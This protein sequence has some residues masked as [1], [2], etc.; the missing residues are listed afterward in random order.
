VNRKKPGRKAEPE[1]KRRTIWPR[2]TGFRG[3]TAWDWMQLLIVP[4]VLTFLGLSF[5]AAQQVIANLQQDIRQQQIE[6]QRAEAEREL[7]E[8]RAQDE[9]LQAYLD[10]M[11]ELLLEHDLRDSGPDSSARAVANVQ[12]LLILERV[13]P[14]RKRS[15]LRLLTDSRL[16]DADAPV[17]DLDDASL[18]GADVSGMDLSG[19]DLS[20]ANLSDAYLSNADLSDANLSGAYLSGADLGGAGGVS[21]QELE[22][23]ASDLTDATMPD[24]SKHP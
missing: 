17:M 18:D 14:A 1:S 5:T 6:D 13:D 21:K 23:E 9:A 2:W 4:L 12:T 19:T 10:L 20:G 3:K 15:V 11:K 7:A 24:G 16:I 8:Q 22:Q